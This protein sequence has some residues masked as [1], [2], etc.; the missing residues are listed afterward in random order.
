[1]AIDKHLWSTQYGFRAARSTSQPIHIIRRIMDFHEAAGKHLL[2]TLLDW[3]K[4][5]D[6]VDQNKLLEA[7]ERLSIPEKLLAAIQSLY[8]NPR[9]RAVDT[10][11][12]SEW[13]KQSSGIRQG[14]PL[15]PLLFVCLMTVLFHDVYN[16]PQVRDKAKDW[17]SEFNITDLLYAD[18]TLLITTTDEAMNILL[19]AIEKESDYYNMKLNKGKCLT[20]T[21]KG[22]SHTHFQN[23]TNLQNVSQAKYR[24]IT[25]DE[26]HQTN[27]T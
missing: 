21:M 19:A 8:K 2:V 4:A 12:N 5:F 18:D 15:S 1:M 10:L 23:G 6:K 14:C 26:K 16:D 11:G 3:E 13:Q 25:L 17:Q 22:T 7:L 20:I 27:Q 9:F 24:G